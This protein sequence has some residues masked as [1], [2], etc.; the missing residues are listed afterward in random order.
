MAKVMKGPAQPNESVQRVVSPKKHAQGKGIVEK[1][2]RPKHQ[3]RQSYGFTPTNPK[4]LGESNMNKSSSHHIKKAMSHLEKAD[5]HHSKAQEHLHNHSQMA[6]S[7][8]SKET[9]NRGR[10][11]PRKAY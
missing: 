11:R 5:H 3:T 1:N 9:H 4:P 6:S 2:P 8:M 10:G 7:H